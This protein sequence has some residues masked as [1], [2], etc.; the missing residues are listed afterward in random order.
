[1]KISGGWILGIAM[2]VIL[3]LCI[4]N[5]GSQQ[6]SITGND[7]TLSPG[8]QWVAPDTTGIGTTPEGELIQYGRKL[9]S[10]TSEF[11]GPNGKV[12]QISNGMNCQNCHL[13]A[14]VRPFGNSLC[15]VAS[16]YPMKRNRSG[17]VESIEFRINDCMIRSLNGS[18]LDTASREMRAMV[19][20]IHWIGKDVPKG[21]RPENSDLAQLPFLSRP[22][23]VINGGIIYVNKC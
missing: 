10:N 11:L 8:S 21:K 12:A 1:M 17:I 9:I 18:P 14:G 20:Y 16:S 6:L 22:A 4:V 3:T 23:D 13:D 19:A 15:G 5:K 7:V 2:V